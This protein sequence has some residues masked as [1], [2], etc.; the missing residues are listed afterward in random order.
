LDARTDGQMHAQTLRLFH[1][2]S[3][4]MLCIGQTTI[5]HPFN[6]KFVT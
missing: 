1:T 6:L 5:C 2:L 3:N 4:A